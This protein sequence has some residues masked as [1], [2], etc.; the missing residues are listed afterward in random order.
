MYADEPYK[1]TTNIRFCQF[2]MRYCFV[3]LRL[4]FWLRLD[5][6]FCVWW[7]ITFNALTKRNTYREL[8]SLIC[9]YNLHS[10]FNIDE[11][12]STGTSN[13]FGK[14]SL[15][16]KSIFNC[17]SNQRKREREIYVLIKEILSL[18]LNFQTIELYDVLSIRTFSIEFSSNENCVYTKYKLCRCTCRVHKFK[19]KILSP[20]LSL[21]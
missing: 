5:S 15:S 16:W 7:N 1:K 8:L 4:P 14:F 13:G 10:I 6:V 19:A 17:G 2:I 21:L 18:V 20:S 12:F 3:K 11:T 9:I